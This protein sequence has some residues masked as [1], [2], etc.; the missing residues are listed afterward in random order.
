MLVKVF[1][2][3]LSSREGRIRPGTRL[4]NHSLLSVALD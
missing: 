2:S 4:L 1:V 3:M